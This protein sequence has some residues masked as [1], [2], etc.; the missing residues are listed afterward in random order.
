MKVTDHFQKVI[1]EYMYQVKAIITIK[2]KSS[3]LLT[4]EI[5]A[6][7]SSYVN[8][9]TS[10]KLALQELRKKLKKFFNSTF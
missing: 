8:Y 4:K 6:T 10:K 7:G 3:I 1:D 2:Y 5:V 9:Q